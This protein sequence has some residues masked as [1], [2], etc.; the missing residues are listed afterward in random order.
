MRLSPALTLST[1]LSTLLS[2]SAIAEPG[3]MGAASIRGLGGGALFLDKGQQDGLEAGV[4]IDVTR[5]GRVVGR[6]IVDAVADH[7]ARCAFADPKA[8]IGRVGDRVRFPRAPI[9]TTTAAATPRTPPPVLADDELAAAAAVVGTATLP[10]VAFKGS[11]RRG[12]GAIAHRLA[13]TAGA[14][15]FGVVGGSGDTVFVR[16]SLDIAGRVGLGLLPGLYAQTALRLQGDA[17]APENERFRNSVPLEAYVWDAS[18]GI[19]PGRSGLTATAGRFRPQRVPGATVVDGASLGLVSFGGALEVGAYGGLIPDPITTAPSLERVTVGSYFAVDTSPVKG[20]MV[21]PRG[22]VGLVTSPDLQRTRAEAEAQVQ[23]LW[24]N[25]VAVS[26][27]L[28]AGL[29]GDTAIPTL[30]A[31]RLDVD[32]TPGRAL[33]ARLGVRTIGTWAGDLDTGVV[34]DGTTMLAP[35]AAHHGDAGVQ[36][37]VNDGL[38]VGATGALSADAETGDLRGLIGPEVSL[39][40]LFG[41]VGGV[42]LGVFEEPGSGV[43]PWGRSGYL[44]TTTRPLPEL[45]PGLVWSVRG[46]VF[47]H[48]AATDTDGKVVLGGALRELLVMSAVSAPLS[49]WLSL[50]GRAHGLFTVVDVDGFGAVPVGAVADLALTARF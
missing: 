44:A 4:A 50:S 18:V 33:R 20:V 46:S 35:R 43:S 17:L 11:R 24:E 28:R 29:P 37:A 42:S 32:V 8:L 16:P 23:V 10:K 45:A 14:R 31:A 9:D 5:R 21:L 34:A 41:D 22:R 15:G 27:S 36:W 7:H 6:C 12:G 1:L 30:D 25:L 49:S 38:V 2:M 39:P 47:E 40:R 26:G 13:I 19:A 48:A 3:P